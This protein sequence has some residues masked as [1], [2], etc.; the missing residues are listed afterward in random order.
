ML[1]KIYPENPNPKAIEQ[2]VDVLKKGGLIIYPT[3]TV[4]GL[5]CDITNQKAIE[6]ICRIRGIKLEKANFSFI[7]HDLSHIA[8]YIKPIDNPTF[9][10]LKKTLPGPFSFIFTYAY[11][12]LP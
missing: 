10:V 5:G 1:I 9:R 3:D 2:V 6:K 11:Q 12:N 8:D 4:Y 7:C